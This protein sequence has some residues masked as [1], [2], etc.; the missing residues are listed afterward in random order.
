M[1]TLSE[2]STDRKRIARE[3]Q[4][5][6]ATVVRKFV[7]DLPADLP[8]YA[9]G[10]ESDRT[11]Y[12]FYRDELRRNLREQPLGYR[13]LGIACDRCKIPLVDTDKGSLRM[14]NPPCFR[15]ACA[16]CGWVGYLTADARQA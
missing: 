16:G 7:A 9:P 8:L 3:E 2:W 15:A 13:L 6:V 4:E 14:S 1:K 12:E 11:N 5:A 10:V